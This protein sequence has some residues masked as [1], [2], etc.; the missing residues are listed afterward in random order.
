MGGS[1]T[2]GSTVGGSTTCGSTLCLR[3]NLGHGAVLCQFILGIPA[4]KPS[5]Q[6]QQCTIAWIG[7][8][9]YEFLSPPGI[10]GLYDSTGRGCG[11]AWVA[12]CVVLV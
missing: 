7:S 8:K 9:A 1:T 6:L 5:E 10:S 3:G 4:Q 2:C 12:E 11:L